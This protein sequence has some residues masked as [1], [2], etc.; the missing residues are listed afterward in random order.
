MTKTFILYSLWR[1]FSGDC[2]EL[3]RL[4]L[5]RN[6]LIKFMG[7][8]CNKW[9]LPIEYTLD[10]HLVDENDDTFAKGRVNAFREAAEYFDQYADTFPSNS[11]QRSAFRYASVKLFALMEQEIGK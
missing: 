6:D 2:K 4:S 1:S 5:V 11:N 10:H 3:V 8:D 7:T 9:T